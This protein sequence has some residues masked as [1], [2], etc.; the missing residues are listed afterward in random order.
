M[1][2]RTGLRREPRAAATWSKTALLVGA[3]AGALLVQALLVAAV[4]A[5]A[6]AGGMTPSP[7]RSQ[8]TRLSIGPSFAFGV[9]NGGGSAA[10]L[11]SSNL[12]WSYRY[13]YLA[14]GVNTGEGW[15]TWNP[16]GSFV[17]NYLRESDEAGVTP[18]FTYYQLLQSRPAAGNDESEKDLSN[19]ANVETMRAYFTDFT[20]LLDRARDYGRPVIVHVEPDLNGYAQQRVIK[21]TNS[22]ASIPAAVAAT[23]LDGLTDLPNTY[24]GF[25]QALLR[26]RDRRAPNVALALH[27][28]AWSTNVDVSTSKD[29]R[30]DVAA[31]AAK[32]AQFLATAGLSGNPEGMSTYDLVFEDPA[33]R[34]AGYQQIVNGDGGSHWWDETNQ[35]LPNF[36]RFEQYLA[37]LHKGIGRPLMLWQVPIGNTIFRSQNNTWNHYQDNR[38]QYWLNGYPGDGR[39]AGLARAGVVAILWGRGA[40]GGTTNDDA[41]RDGVTNPAPINGNDRVATVA[42]DDGGLLREVLGRY[43]QQPLRL[44]QIVPASSASGPVAAPPAAPVASVPSS[45]VPTTTRPAPPSQSETSRT[46]TTSAPARIPTSAGTADR[47][48][49]TVEARGTRSVR[50]LFQAS[51]VAPGTRVRLEVDGRTVLTPTILPVTTARR[52]TARGTSKPVTLTAGRHVVSV[53]IE[54]GSARLTNLRVA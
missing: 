36:S 15:A 23:G 9:S 29:P 20:L 37:A 16:D 19:L 32:T 6:T 33:D 27:A 3:L 2:S 7:V 34:D 8:L 21:T 25:N 12:P 51:R 11:R 42:D 28:S 10:Q 47:L 35:R 24:Q 1:S 14:G 52:P 17:T 44:D 54:A 38:V 48:D 46:T 30:L 26:L 45:V 13:Q 31:I 4:P 5:P 53:V 43:A 49:L 41:A 40:D 39:L 18:V 22:A 50:I